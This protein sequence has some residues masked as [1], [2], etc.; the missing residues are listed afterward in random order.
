MRFLLPSDWL[1]TGP[2]ALKLKPSAA[3][4]S[5]FGRV[6]RGMKGGRG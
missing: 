4:G 6:K 3:G 1:Q 2:G 5:G